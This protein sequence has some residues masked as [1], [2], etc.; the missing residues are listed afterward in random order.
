MSAAQLSLDGVGTQDAAD[1][2]GSAVFACILAQR[3]GDS[4]FRL[5]EKTL[6]ACLRPALAKE[7][8]KATRVGKRNPLFDA[9]AA[10]CGYSDPL[11]RT[12]AGQVAQALA[13]IKAVC[14]AVS[15]DDLKR[16]ALAV[17][18]KYEGAGPKAV[19]AHWGSY[20]HL[21]ANGVKVSLPTAPAGWLAKLNELFPDSTMAKGGVHEIAKESE[22]NWLRLDPSIQAM[23]RKAIL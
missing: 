13:E 10:G 1:R 4:G 16:T 23:L 5:T 11:T 19:S 12:A 15:A 21:R 14:P 17:C 3:K 22:Y 20:G 18:K 9:L 7:L 2:I 8:P 6:V